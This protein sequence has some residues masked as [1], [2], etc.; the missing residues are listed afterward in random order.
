MEH[1]TTHE[2]KTRLSQ[3]LARVEQ[4]EEFTICRGTQ[5]VARLTSISALKGETGRPKVG[6][7][8][9]GPVTYASDAFE[10]MTGP[11]LEEWGL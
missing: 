5:P 2:A 9:T 1:V 4:G 10:A 3:L 6:T 11:E 8:T 7:I